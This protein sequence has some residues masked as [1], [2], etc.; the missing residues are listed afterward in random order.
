MTTGASTAH[1]ESTVTLTGRKLALPLISPLPR[2]AN[3]A[4]PNA[5]LCNYGVTVI[6]HRVRLL[7]A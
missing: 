1:T 7:E 5:G 6:G 4:S 3:R 2:D